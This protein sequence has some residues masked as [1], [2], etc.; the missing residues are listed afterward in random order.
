MGT[1]YY[2]SWMACLWVVSYLMSPIFPENYTFLA[3]SKHVNFPVPKDDPSDWQL[4]QNC[5]H[6][7]LQ[8]EASVFR[9]RKTTKR[10]PTQI[11]TAS[12]NKWSRPVGYLDNH[13]ETHPVLLDISEIPDR[14]WR[15]V[16]LAKMSTLDILPI[17]AVV[18]I[19]ERTVPVRVYGIRCHPYSISVGVPQGLVLAS[20][21]FCPP[22]IFYPIPPTQSI[23]L[24]MT[25]LHYFV[26]HH[27]ACQANTLNKAP[28]DAIIKP[29]LM[30]S[31]P[32]FL[33]FFEV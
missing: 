32:L 21:L 4:S 25:S 28:E 12:S 30:L 18:E 26:S 33:H 5:L 17:S 9:T 27:T 6:R 22:L 1:T 10:L 3:P 8:P 11:W 19:N 16:C 7:R 13:R 20:T 29:Q 24:P 31:K 14:D 2:L 23:S 15:E